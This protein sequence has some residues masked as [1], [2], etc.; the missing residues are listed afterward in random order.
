MKNLY[1]TQS[2]KRVLW[3]S[4]FARNDFLL[5]VFSLQQKAPTVLL[6]LKIGKISW[7][8]MLSFHKNP[9]SDHHFVCTNLQ[10]SVSRCKIFIQS[11][12][13]VQILWE[14]CHKSKINILSAHFRYF[15]LNNACGTFDAF[16]W[17]S[18][19][20]IVVHPLP[21]RNGHRESACLPIDRPPFYR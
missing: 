5:M 12:R 17:T 4:F 18:H 3:N 6:V 8:F 16:P 19:V 9:H 1:F 13:D 20:V 2:D 14:N 11:A 10:F 21:A 7:K 15:I